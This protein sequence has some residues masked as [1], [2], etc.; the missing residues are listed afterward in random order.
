MSAEIA[1][2]IVSAVVAG[3]SNKEIAEQF[4]ISEDTVKHHLSKIFH[5]LGVSWR[6]KFERLAVGVAHISD[7]VDYLRAMKATHNEARMR[8]V[9]LTP[10][11]LEIVAKVRAGY[12]S[13]EIAE[14]LKMSEE[15]LNHYLKNIIDQ[16]GGPD[17]RDEAGIAVNSDDRFR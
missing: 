1:V 10:L 15:R 13:P 2:E 5:K 6:M 17:E 8:K 16:L 4:K 11:E 9:G 3:C 7:C 12:Y 14:H